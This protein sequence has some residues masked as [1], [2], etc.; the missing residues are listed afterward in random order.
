MGTR[1]IAAG[2]PSKLFVKKAE[3]LARRLGE[4]DA[5]LPKPRP[6]VRVAQDDATQLATVAADSIDFA[7]TSPPYAGTYDYLA[8]HAMRMRWLGLDPG[9]L[10]SGEIGARRRYAPLG[11]D[12]ARAAWIAE[13]RAVLAATARV[14]R[15]GGFLV[16]LL[17]DSA[18]GQTPLRAPDV[19]EAAASGSAM[20]PVARA[21]QERPHFH[22]PTVA[23]FR[24]TPRREHALLLVKR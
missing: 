6:S 14:L 7:L 20:E 24:H 11:P 1:R 3:E 2:Y 23:L 17:G 22:G 10:S 5:L 21:S 15:R 16:M 13:L 18:V 19:V 9:A 8:H 12:E 4:L